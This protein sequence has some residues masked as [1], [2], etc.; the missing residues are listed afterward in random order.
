MPLSSVAALL[1][2]PAW[3]LDR[4]RGYERRFLEL[5]QYRATVTQAL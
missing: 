1:P 5:L 3:A 2:Q 4:I